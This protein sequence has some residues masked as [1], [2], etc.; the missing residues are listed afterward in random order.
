MRAWPGRPYPL[1]AIWDGSGTHFALFSQ[2]A[3][4]VQL[5]LYDRPDAA[6]PRERVGVRERT[7]HVWHV[8]LPDVRP[9]DLYGYRVSGPYAPEQGHRFNPAKLLVDPYARAL[10]GP[11]RWS[12]ALYG[13]PVDGPRQDLEPSPWNSD[14]FVPKCVVTD[15]TFP[16]GDDRPLRTPWNRTVIY[17][18]HVKGMTAR[19]PELPEP[20]RGTYRGLASEP[21][22]DHLL[23]LGVTAV[24]LLPVHHA[25]S[26]HALLRRG[27]T[28]YWGYNTLG[29]FAPDSRFATDTRGGQV[30]EFKSMVK[31]L[32][33]AGI[34]V[35][36]DVV[37]NHTAEG[38]HLGPTLS[39]RG[40]DNASYYLLD[41]E[42]PRRYLDFTGCGNTFDTSHP[43]A[44]QLVMDSLRYWVSEMHVDGFRFDLAPALARQLEEKAGL[45]RLFDTIQ[46]DPLLARVKLIAEPWDLGPDGY[47]VGSF[48]AGWAEW[49]GEYRDTVRRFWRGSDGRWA[50]SRRGCREARTCTRPTRARPRRASTS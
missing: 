45:G 31:A 10:T 40:I 22:I 50:R 20:E 24:E 25:V 13:Y 43:R 3:T 26:E 46:Q 8:Y 36:L 6:E 21:V 34:E 42:A 12:D 5:C 33:A 11:V 1:G 47:H 19:H 7:D 29:F 48:P 17:E 14:A 2:H 39:L 23:A 37:Y 4:G 35:I 30:T 44:L 16:W 32:H 49:N 28:N 38:D 18:C 9:G 15:D 41:P 27:L